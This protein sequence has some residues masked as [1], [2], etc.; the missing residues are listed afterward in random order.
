MYE[1]VVTTCYVTEC[2]AV[3]SESSHYLPAIHAYIIHIP[4]YYAVPG[5]PSAT[6]F[7]STCPAWSMSWMRW[8]SSHALA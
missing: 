5:Y 7:F 8:N 4:Y 3:M 1:M 6:L 2:P